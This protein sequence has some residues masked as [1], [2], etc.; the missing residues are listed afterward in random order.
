MSKFNNNKRITQVFV[1][2]VF[3]VFI[4]SC[5]GNSTGNKSSAEEMNRIESAY[6]DGK[7]VGPIK[8]VVINAEIDNNLAKKGEILYQSK[9][10]SCHKTS[11]E[12][13]IGPGLSGITDRRRP[14]WIMN[15]LLNPIG[16]TQN[17]SLSKVLLSIYYAQMLDNALKQ[18]EARSILEYLRT[19]K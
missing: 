14:E 9:C 3:I 4:Y 10:V 18:E 16:M 7:G 15:M 1:L 5:G 11:R 17:D 12:K 19:V 6:Y 8:E 13:L 2:F